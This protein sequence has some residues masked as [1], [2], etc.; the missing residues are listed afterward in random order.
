[1]IQQLEHMCGFTRDDTA[2]SRLAKL[3]ARLGDIAEHDLGLIAELSLLPTGK[4][5]PVVQSAPQKNASA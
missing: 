5:F 4:R 1:M 3:E 2:E